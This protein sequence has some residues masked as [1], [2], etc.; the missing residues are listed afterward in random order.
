M[1]KNVVEQERVAGR[2]VGLPDGKPVG[3]GPLELVVGLVAYV[4]LLVPGTLWLLSLPADG[5]AAGHA[6]LLVSG[7]AGIGAFALAAL[8]RIRRLDVFGFRRASGGQL[9]VGAGFGVLAYFANAAVVAA[10]TVLVANDNPQGGYQ[11]A[12]GA[13]ALS[14]VVSLLAGALLTPL[15]E[16][17]LFRG[18]VANA[19]G[20]YG[21]WAGV[22]LSS[23]VF[24]LAHGI[25]VILPV[26]FLVG[27]LSAVLLRRTGSIW[28]SVLVHAVN[29][30]LGV[31]AAAVLLG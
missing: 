3:P 26:A 20:R 18:V 5:A 30:G 31:V 28:P 1:T 17:L 11:A 13:G 9:A 25:N 19:L 29:N 16:E 10:Y 6:G 7:G 22:P 27:V 14:F 23:A 24:A 21:W 2:P 4:A 15:G 12:A 8:V